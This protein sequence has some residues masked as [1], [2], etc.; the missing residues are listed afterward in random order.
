MLHKERQ[1]N[2][3]EKDNLKRNGKKMRY[4]KKGQILKADKMEKQRLRGGNIDKTEAIHLG[5]TVVSYQ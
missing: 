3:N 1:Q 2:K 4:Q 5:L